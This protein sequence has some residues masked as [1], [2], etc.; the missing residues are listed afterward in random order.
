L[1]KKVIIRLRTLGTTAARRNSL[2]TIFAR[3]PKHKC[4]F[5]V[6]YSIELPK[7]LGLRH[8]LVVRININTT[9]TIAI[10]HR[11]TTIFDEKYS[12]KSNLNAPTFYDFYLTPLCSSQFLLAT[13]H[14]TLFLDLSQ[15][16]D[17]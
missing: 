8:A 5:C 17:Y 6:L 14:V 10:Y 13:W 2:K 11:R 3:D 15:V 9:T 16:E 7:E 4:Y 12:Y 1:R